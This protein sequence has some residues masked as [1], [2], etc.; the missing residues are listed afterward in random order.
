MFSYM[1]DSVAQHDYV[2]SRRAFI[3]LQCCLCIPNQ[4]VQVND[5]WHLHRTVIGHMLSFTSPA[6]AAEVKTRN[7]RYR[8]P[9]QPDMSSPKHSLTKGSG[10][11][12]KPCSP[13]TTAAAHSRSNCGGGNTRQ[14]TK[15]SSS[16]QAGRVTDRP[17]EMGSLH[18][19]TAGLPASA[20]WSIKCF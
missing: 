4:D 19:P 2:C 5:E 13:S 7:A 17:L 15:E 16:T 1:I 9:C 11:D 10:S 14:S 12:E 3:V 6:V 18:E 8:A 20:A